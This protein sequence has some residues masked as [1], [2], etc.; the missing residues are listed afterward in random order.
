VRRCRSPTECQGYRDDGFSE[1]VLWYHL[2]LAL[3]YRRKRSVRTVALWMILPPEDQPRDTLTVNDIT[4]KVK[5]IVLP[6]VPASVLLADPATAC[7]A[8][9]ADAE[10][11]SDDALCAEVAAGLKTRDASW[12]ERHMAVVAAAMRERYH[13]MVNA[14]EQANLEPV[15]IEDLVKIGEDMGRVEMGRS[16][17]RSVL[18]LRKLVLGADAE[19]RIAACTDPAT[20]KRWVDQA[21]LAASPAE[22]LQ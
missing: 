15:V 16:V 4:V 10:G 1:R 8:A 3:R 12:A 9:G 14:M 6:K 21:V 22:V 5:T 17:L 20:L 11:R 13:A 18:A 7:F 19:A 2:G